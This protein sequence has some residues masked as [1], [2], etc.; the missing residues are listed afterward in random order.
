MIAK[1]TKEKAIRY[2]RY[3]QE[4]VLSKFYNVRE[5]IE[6]LGAV[7]SV[8]QRCKEVQQLPCGCL[9]LP[10]TLFKALECSVRDVSSRDGPHTQVKLIKGGVGKPLN[11]FVAKDT[12]WIV[13]NWRDRIRRVGIG[14]VSGLLNF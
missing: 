5:K 9:S 2:V 13:A 7:A 3:W 1:T 11:S 14:S 12:F 6:Y 8:Y 4:H 10:E